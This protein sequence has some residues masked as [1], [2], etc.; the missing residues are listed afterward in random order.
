MS[1]RAASYSDRGR[2]VCMTPV[3]NRVDFSRQIS[4][5]SVFFTVRVAFIVDLVLG[6]VGNTSALCV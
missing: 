4:L 6:R 3:E 5:L 2:Y 1:S